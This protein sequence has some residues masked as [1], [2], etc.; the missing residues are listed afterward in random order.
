MSQI[1][2]A[3]QLSEFPSLQ[4]LRDWLQLAIGEN[5][6]LLYQAYFHARRAVQLCPLQGEAYLYLAEVCF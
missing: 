5:S 4:Q 2:E 1:R 6:R 3:A